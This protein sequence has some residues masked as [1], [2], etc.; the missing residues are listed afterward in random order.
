MQ[1]G[2]Q[3]KFCPDRVLIGTASQRSK[4]TSHIH[5]AQSRYAPF[6]IFK[7]FQSK[8]AIQ[9]KPHFT[10]SRSHVKTDSP[11]LS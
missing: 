10:I 7:P 5:A 1:I 3:K 6:S 4:G 8:R 2:E 11:F 9:I